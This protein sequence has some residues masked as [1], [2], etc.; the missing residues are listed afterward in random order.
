[1]LLVVDRRSIPR[2]GGSGCWLRVLNCLV[3]LFL[4]FLLLVAGSW[5]TGYGLRV[6][7]F[8]LFGVFVAGCRSKIDPSK[9]GWFLGCGLR[10]AGFKLFGVW[11]LVFVVFVP[12]FWLKL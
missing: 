8:K 6:T 7:G 12:G 2:R 5:V 3:F 10:V 4:L 1:M 9:R 11:F